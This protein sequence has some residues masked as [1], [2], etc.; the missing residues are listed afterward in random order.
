MP[1]AVQEFGNDVGQYRLDGDGAVAVFGCRE[2]HLEGKYKDNIYLGLHF[3]KKSMGPDGSLWEPG[4]TMYGQGLASMALVEALLHLTYD[5]ALR[6]CVQKATNFNVAAQDKEAAGCPRQS[7]HAGRCLGVRLGT[8]G[9]RKVP[10][11][12]ICM[13]R[14]IPS[15][16]ADYFLD[17]MQL[18]GGAEYAYFG[19][20]RTKGCETGAPTGGMPAWIL[21]ARHL[22]D[23]PAVPDVFGLEA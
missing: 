21:V 9:G 23:R 11:W 19:H 6:R 16:K 4:G 2:T 20:L 8:D 13:C 3:L 5:V 15:A 22:S 17:T 18:N 14:K 10:A 7:R 12:L 1:R